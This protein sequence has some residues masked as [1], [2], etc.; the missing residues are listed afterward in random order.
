MLSTT[1]NYSLVVLVTD[2]CRHLTF[3]GVGHGKQCIISERGISE[4]LSEI[5]IMEKCDFLRSLICSRIIF[6]LKMNNCYKSYLAS[7]D[8]EISLTRNLY[9]TFKAQNTASAD[10]I[11]ESFFFI[12]F[13]RK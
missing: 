8:N 9:L 13:Q 7:L 5:H 12:G 10:D 1:V 2:L 6:L 4:I 3:N 11:L